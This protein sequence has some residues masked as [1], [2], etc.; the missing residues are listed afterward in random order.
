[1]EIQFTNEKQLGHLATSRT[2]I[3]QTLIESKLR[4]NVVGVVAKSVREGM[5]LCAVRE[6]CRD[7]DEDDFL[8]ILNQNVLARANG[9]GLTLYLSEIT[10]LCTI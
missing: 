5:F 6:I 7:E 10:A 4:E 1:M 2:E 3:L 8:V 9:D